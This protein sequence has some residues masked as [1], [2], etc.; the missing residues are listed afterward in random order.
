LNERR[1]R[2]RRILAVLAVVGVAAATAAVVRSPLFAVS[3]VRVDGV[4]GERAAEV[5]DAGNVAVGQNVL[6]VDLDQLKADVGRLPWVAR[7]SASREPPATVAVRVVPREPLAVVIASGR[8]LVVDR[9]GVVI[10][11]GAASGLAPISAT[12]TVPVPPGHAI[13]DDGVSEALS[14]HSALQP[15]VRRMVIGYSVTEGSDV[16]AQMRTSDVVVAV[17]LGTA[18]RLADKQRALTSL[19]AE[20]GDDPTAGITIDVRAPANPVVVPS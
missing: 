7:V 10:E 9:A 11:T 14:I 5:R 8:P 20:L 2:R 18:E 19:L 3:S 15:R 16:V 13:R 4:S 6:S 17:R 1:S 12:A